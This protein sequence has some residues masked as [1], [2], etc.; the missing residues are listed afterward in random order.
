MIPTSGFS[1]SKYLILRMES[2]GSKVKDRVG[3]K[4]KGKGGDRPRTG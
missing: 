3:E 1:V 4:G 2:G